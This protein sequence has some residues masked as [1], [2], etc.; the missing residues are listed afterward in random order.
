M[1]K[2]SV[3]N[4]S[5]FILIIIATA[6]S[7]KMRV[8]VKEASTNHQE[9]KNTVST[10]TPFSNNHIAEGQK[11]Y[12]ASCGRCH[13]LHSPG[14]YTETEWQPIMRSMARKAK[15]GDNEKEMVLAY[16]NANAKK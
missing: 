9:N 12:N 8:T 14:E 7:S 1:N 13:E 3:K 2:I 5:V 11:I 15:L 16:V 10:V 4:I 6:C